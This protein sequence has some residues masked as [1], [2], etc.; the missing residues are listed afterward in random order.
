MHH[1]VLPQRTTV[2][3]RSA[4]VW[5]DL[6]IFG[7]I[8]SEKWSTPHVVARPKFLVGFF[9]EYMAMTVSTSGCIA[10]SRIIISLLRGMC[11]VSDIKMWGT[12]VWKYLPRESHVCHG[13]AAV[14][15]A[16]CAPVMVCHDKIQ[17]I[18]NSGAPAQEHAF[19]GVFC[20]ASCT[21]HWNEHP[22][23]VPCT[24]S[25]CPYTVGGEGDSVHVRCS[26]SNCIPH[27]NYWMVRRTE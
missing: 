11:S 8:T 7:L 21:D 6:E 13:V 25:A 2:V 16:V 3:S 18:T 20:G 26:A 15:V 19:H 9:I 4:T 10:R 5:S 14:Y 24:V 27:V 1:S 22:I 12:F 17:Y 23:W